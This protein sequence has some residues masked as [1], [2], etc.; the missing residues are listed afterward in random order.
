MTSRLWFVVL[1]LAASCAPPERHEAW[2]VQRVTPTDR[3]EEITGVC[4]DVRTLALGSHADET[5]LE[6][7]LDELARLAATTGATAAL[8]LLSDI[9]ALSADTTLSAHTIAVQQHDLL[10]LASRSIDTATAT[11]CGIPAFSALYATSG[12]PDC[13]FEMEIPVAAYTNV[14]EAGTCSA[15]GRPTFLPCWTDDGHHLPIDCVGGEIVQAVG[16]RW[17]P[18]GEPRIVEID[19]VD[20]GAPEGPEVLAPSDV[21][22]CVGLAALF[23]T[24]APSVSKIDRLVDAT[25]MLDSEIRGLVG[26]FIAATVDPPDLAEFES[27]VSSLD[28]ATAQA[29]GVPV[30]SALASIP[31]AVTQLPCWTPTGNPYP[32]YEIL[33]CLDQ[34]DSDDA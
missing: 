9:G 34:V 19:R 26:E 23:E 28:S 15:D 24:E 13:H 10:V 22:E 18:A 8:P 30:A 21:P 5:A 33:D 12:F 1:L 25:A 14:G 3:V 6:G 20:P 31:T 27:I 29:C 4:Q 17:D 11:A 16:D 32:A 2:A 7:T